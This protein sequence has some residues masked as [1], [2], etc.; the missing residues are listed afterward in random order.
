M[1]INR[2]NQEYL[3][4][5]IMAARNKDRNAILQRARIFGLP[6]KTFKEVADFFNKNNLEELYIED[7]G[8]SLTLK[9]KTQQQAPASPAPVAPAAPVP[10]AATETEPKEAPQAAVPQGE[11][12]NSPIIG[13][14]YASPSPDNPSYVKTGD[15][16]EADSTL[17]IVEAMK[18]M[19][20]I[21]AEKKLKIKNILVKNAESVIQDQPLFE[22]EYL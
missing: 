12:V 16:V 13:T 21:K 6:R 11:T 19:N 18:I 3:Q 20:E 7:K 1:P 8:V 14:F 4:E 22:V 17:C 9:K 5:K 2:Y 15:V 10:V